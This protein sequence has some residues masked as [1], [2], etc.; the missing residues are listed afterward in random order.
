MMGQ[1]TPFPVGKG[2][3]DATFT[4]YTEEDD[5]A[6]R[7]ASTQSA[8]EPLPLHI[9]AAS[10]LRR[11]YAWFVALTQRDIGALGQ[12]GLVHSLI[13]GGVGGGPPR[14][15]VLGLSSLGPL[16]LPLDAEAVNRLTLR[17]ID[18]NDY[19]NAPVRHAQGCWPAGQTSMRVAAS[20]CSPCQ[21]H[22]LAPA[23]C[24][25]LAG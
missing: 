7:Y 25:L 17:E 19:Y 6:D 2:G 12:D 14:D 5:H 15:S 9:A 24:L 1:L 22:V 20:A 3:V 16:Q 10:L 8:P 11:G 4:M 23:V 18:P 21:L 13:S